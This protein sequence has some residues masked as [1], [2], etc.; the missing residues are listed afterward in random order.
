MNPRDDLVSD[1]LLFQTLGDDLAFEVFDL[2]TLRRRGDMRQ[3]LAEAATDLHQQEAP[4]AV[5]IEE[6]GDILLLF[7]QLDE[8]RLDAG[9]HRRNRILESELQQ[10]TN[11]IA[12]FNDDDPFGILDVRSSGHAVELYLC[13]EGQNRGNLVDDVPRF[14]RTGL[15][16]LHQQHL[17]TIDDRVALR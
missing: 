2:A 3:R 1:L 6:G 17:R 5:S 11:I 14:I 4:A 8:F 9:P 10:V 12:S 16:H 13:I 7:R 15:Y